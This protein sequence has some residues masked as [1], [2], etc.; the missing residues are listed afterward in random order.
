MKRI[1]AL[2]LILAVLAIGAGRRSGPQQPIAFSHRIMAGYNKVDCTF[3]HP[4]ASVSANAGMPPVDKCLT[5]HDNIPFGSSEIEK[6][7][8]YRDRDKPI[9]WVRVYKI[10]DFVRFSHEPHIAA[11]RTCEECHG[12]VRSTEVIT[13]VHKMK[14]GFCIDCHRQNKVST[15][16]YTCHY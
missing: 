15:D 13:P 16:C 6:I 7:R 5:C 8:D 14:M 1:V 3:C 4:Y 10:A 9:P 2:V 11:N 12:D